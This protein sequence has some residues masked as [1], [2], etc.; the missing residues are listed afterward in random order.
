MW[1]SYR[2]ES[3]LLALSLL[4]GNPFLRR[5]TTDRRNFLAI[6]LAFIPLQSR[7]AGS[8]CRLIA[9]YF[10]TP[11]QILNNETTVSYPVAIKS[12]TSL[13]RTFSTLQ[14][15][16]LLSYTGYVGFSS[17]K[18]ERSFYPL[19]FS[20]SAFSLAFYKTPSFK[21]APSFYHLSGKTKKPSQ[22]FFARFSHLT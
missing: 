8:F 3:I 19:Q 9:R 2:R 12:E 17:P 6:V 13:S 18:L 7:F 16:M 10:P 22:D 15:R 14:T 1:E 11:P 4:R 21:L 20:A 5:E